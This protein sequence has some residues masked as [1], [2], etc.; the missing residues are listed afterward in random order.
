MKAATAKVI[1]SGDFQAIRLPKDFRV[2]SST[3]KLSKTATG[4]IVYEVG[5][6]ARRLKLKAFK[7]LAGSCVDFPKTEA[8]TSRNVRRNWE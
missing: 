3:V 2:K 1:N 8:N 5:P 7:A 4:F 6:S